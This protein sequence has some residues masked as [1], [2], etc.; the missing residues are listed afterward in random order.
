LGDG[1]GYGGYGGY[2]GCCWSCCYF[3]AL[4]L[5]GNA[6]ME[7]RYVLYRTRGSSF[8]FPFL[9]SFLSFSFS[10][11]LLFVL[12]ARG[13]IPIAGATLRTISRRFGM[14]DWPRFFARY[15]TGDISFSNGWASLLNT[16]ILTRY[17]PIISFLY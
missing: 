4:T 14:Q 1:S 8:S 15:S 6:I 3:G 2:G 17:R 7:S 10:F 16:G 11:F 9:F 5:P 12:K 13:L